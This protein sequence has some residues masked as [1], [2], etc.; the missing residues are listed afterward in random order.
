[1]A[2]DLLGIQAEGFRL[3]GNVAVVQDVGGG[4]VQLIAVV[5]DEVDDVVQLVGVCEVER[6]PDLA[7]VGLAVAGCCFRC[8]R[9]IARTRRFCRAVRLCGRVAGLL[10]R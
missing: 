3:L 4:A 7:L 2:V 1:M 5:V 10:A 9:S 6:L 8:A